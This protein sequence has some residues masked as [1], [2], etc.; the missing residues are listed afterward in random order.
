LIELM[1]VVAIIGVLAAIAIPAY[2]D[3]VKRARMSEVLSAFD[4]LAT[5]ANEYHAV[6]GFF[7]SETYGANNLALFSE[8][9]ATITLHDA[10]DSFYGITIIANF[11]ANLD[12]YKASVNQGELWMEVTYNTTTGYGKSWALANTTIDA[13]FIPKK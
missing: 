11:S 10:A 13:M 5:G 2:S 12:L 4:A 6:L 1:I 7:P 3:Y 8:E 9:Y